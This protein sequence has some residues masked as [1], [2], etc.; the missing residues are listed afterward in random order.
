MTTLPLRERSCRATTFA[1]RGAQAV[2]VEIELQYTGGLM[3]RIIMTGLPGGALRE[4]RDRIRG[5]LERCGLP[6]PRRS[7]LANFAPADL[8]KDG[9]GFD[10]PLAVGMLALGEVVPPE[11]LVGRALLGELALDGRLRPVRGALLCA[12]AAHRAG[13][14]A[15]MLP[16]EN[17]AEA[18]LVAGLRVEA[19]S[20]LTEAL[21]VLGGAAPAPLPPVPEAPRLQLDLS[22]V[23]GQASARRA[24]EVAAAGR[25]NLLLCGPPGTGKTML[26]QRL[27]GLLPPLEEAAALEI[28]ALHGLT[29]G[30]RGILRHPPFRAP[31]HTISRAGLIGGGRPL[32]PGEVSL[33]HGGVLFLDEMPEFSRSLLE[34]LRQPLED[35]A[36]RLARAADTVSFPADVQLV[37][38]MNPC[39]CG[40]LGHPKRGCRCTEHQLNSYRQRL[41]GPLLDRFDL[42]IEVQPAPAPEIL[43]G[44]PGEASAVVARRVAAAR[45][46]R[47][48]SIEPKDLPPTLR[49]RLEAQVNAFSLSGRSV[50]RLLAVSRSIAALDN[51]AELQLADLDEALSFRLGLLS[52]GAPSTA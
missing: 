34:G 24:L 50:S 35:R 40:F 43:S 31:H 48:A 11:A 33:A 10:L 21:A 49:Q 4:A 25:H 36:V 42:F 44:E 15:I 18:Q 37:G 22:D 26:A 9:N 5:C 2:P 28:T 12:L 8:P 17:A 45:S 19:V 29:G 7:V 3:Q 16:R 20:S 27:P 1:L 47:R 38:A 30:P 52:F 41:S 39:A 51:R 6:V 23:R 14:A 32:A 13:L 46:A